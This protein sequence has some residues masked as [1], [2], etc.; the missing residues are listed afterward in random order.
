MPDS[1][2]PLPL[3]DDG[4]SF[5]H[6]E[7]QPLDGLQVCHCLHAHRPQDCRLYPVA[8]TQRSDFAVGPS[9]GIWRSL[10]AVSTSIS[11]LVP[12]YHSYDSCSSGRGKDHRPSDGPISHLARCFAC[13][14]KKRAE[15]REDHTGRLR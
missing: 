12:S 3:D 2:G 6:L 7:P 13:V 1:S 11:A 10:F 14:R 5:Y 15:A 9:P 8:S 4:I